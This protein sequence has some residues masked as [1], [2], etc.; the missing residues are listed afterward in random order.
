MHEKALVYGKVCISYNWCLLK[1]KKKKKNTQP[2]V[3]KLET[4]SSLTCFKG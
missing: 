1:K 3:H 2:H 4:Q